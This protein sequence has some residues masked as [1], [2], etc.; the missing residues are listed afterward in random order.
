[1]YR[2]QALKTI[3][4]SIS[5]LISYG[6]LCYISL[7]NHH[8]PHT[9]TYTHYTSNTHTHTLHTHHYT[10]TISCPKLTTCIQWWTFWP[11]Y[12]P[13]RK[14]RQILFLSCISQWKFTK[15]GTRV[16]KSIIKHFLPK[17]FLKISRNKA[18]LAILFK[19]WTLFLACS[20]VLG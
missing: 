18:F 4:F 13:A 11:I 6:S 1:M 14:F 9:H 8:H 5:F 20:S 2:F 17:E 10:H 12:A 16:E 15:N 19:W 7:S 3:C